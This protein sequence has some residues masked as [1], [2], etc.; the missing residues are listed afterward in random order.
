MPWLSYINTGLTSSV[1]AA[2]P[3]SFPFLD[4]VTCSP[5]YRWRPSAEC[6]YILHGPEAELQVKS[7]GQETFFLPLL[8][9]PPHPSPPRIRELNWPP[10][11]T[12][13]LAFFQSRCSALQ[14][15]FSRRWKQ[16]NSNEAGILEQVINFPELEIWKCKKKKKNGDGKNPKGE[17]NR[18]QS[19]TWGGS[20]KLRGAFNARLWQTCT[21]RGSA[22]EVVISLTLLHPDFH[23]CS[24][25]WGHKS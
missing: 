25:K 17:W 24:W 11:E 5:R 16:S 8:L 10:W 12:C 19:I 13:S 18:L 20:H 4:S 7:A 3:E 22:W 23:G 9:Q 21:K 2:P 6:I 14:P 1:S 15:G